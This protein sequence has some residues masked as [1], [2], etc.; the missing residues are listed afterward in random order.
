MPHWQPTGRAMAGIILVCLLCVS[1]V[2][3]QGKIADRV[4]VRIEDDVILLSDVLTADRFQQ[5]WNA[6]PSTIGT[7][8][9]WDKILRQ[10]IDQWIVGREATAVRFPRPKPDE[11]QR[12]YDR[13]AQQYGSV[14]TLKARM[15]EL[16]LSVA[17]VRRLIERQFYLLRYL[18]YK[19]RSAIQIE[20]GEIDAYYRDELVPQLQRRNQTAPSIEQVE[21]QIRGVLVE[22][23]L[24][25]KADQWIQE[26]SSRVSVEIIIDSPEKIKEA[27]KGSGE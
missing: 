13:L 22:R 9:G 5:L 24:T 25:Q 27:G 6:A 12:A 18:D 4:V 10:L 21:E 15:A 19:F 2:A 8:E 16:E 20:R 17:A 14:E 23:K 3:A 26:T 1:T 11:V 7:K